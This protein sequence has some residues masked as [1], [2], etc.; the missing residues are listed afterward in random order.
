MT[1]FDYADKLQDYADRLDRLDPKRPQDSETLR[2]TARK[3]ATQAAEDMLDKLQPQLDNCTFAHFVRV[4][5]I[6][7]LLSK[8]KS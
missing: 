3:L 7:A 2:T 8:E 1:V 6:N 5:G 4:R